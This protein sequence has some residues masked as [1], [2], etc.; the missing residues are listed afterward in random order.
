MATFS[1]V[2]IAEI[3]HRQNGSP[4][5][6]S[7]LSFLSTNCPT[8]VW[9]LRNIQRNTSQGLPLFLSLSLALVVKGCGYLAWSQELVQHGLVLFENGK[10]KNKKLASSSSL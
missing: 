5:T 2:C 10:R 4:C 9:T 7:G 3:G 1:W 6:N 8:V